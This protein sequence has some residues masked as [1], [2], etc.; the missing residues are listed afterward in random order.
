MNTSQAFKNTLEKFDI[1]ASDLSKKSG[2]D[3]QEISRFKNGRKDI[4]SQRL[5]TLV[6]AMPLHAQV[7]FW[8]L[9]MEENNSFLI[10]C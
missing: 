3:Q 2:I 4:V 5:M 7:Y 6:R 1:K 9:C 8:S 10:A